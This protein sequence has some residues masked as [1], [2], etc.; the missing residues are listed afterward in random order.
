M[1]NEK[2]VLKDSFAKH[3]NIETVLM[4]EG[5]A[6]AKIIVT[7][8]YLNGA[9]TAHGGLLFSLA[10]YTFALASN[11]GEDSALGVNAN[12]NYMKRVELQEELTA[13]AFLVSRS[14]Y[15]GTYQVSIYNKKK[16]IVAS[17]QFMAYFKSSI[18]KKKE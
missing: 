14:R 11:A 16:E 3:L 12:I 7:E 8:E 2:L 17:G 9:G 18:S 13:E 10:D 15:L 5:H 1:T 4:E 6:K